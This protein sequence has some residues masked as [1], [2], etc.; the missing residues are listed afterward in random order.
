[1]CPSDLVVLGGN[2]QGMFSLEERLEVASQLK[3]SPPSIA[4]DKGM[5]KRRLVVSQK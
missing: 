3:Q 1:M 5:I 4:R 2:I